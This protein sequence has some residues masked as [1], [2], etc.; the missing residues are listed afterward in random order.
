MQT[1]T[2]G[3]ILTVMRSFGGG[4]SQVTAMFMVSLWLEMLRW[5]RRDTQTARPTFSS[6]VSMLRDPGQVGSEGEV[7][8]FWLNPPPFH[9]IQPT[10]WLPHLPHSKADKRVFYLSS[11]HSDILVCGGTSLSVRSVITQPLVCRKK[12]PRP[13]RCAHR[14]TSLIAGLSNS[15]RVMRPWPAAQMTRQ[16]NYRKSY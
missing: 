13:A 5:Q 6:A 14:H 4:A 2:R 10:R 15:K 9:E 7:E 11:P 12:R 1:E 16:T 3:T 8:P